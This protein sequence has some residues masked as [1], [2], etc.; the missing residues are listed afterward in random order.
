MNRSKTGFLGTAAI[1]VFALS[2]AAC[3]VQAAGS[4]GT[5]PPPPP[6]AT[7]AAPPPA[8]TTAAPA[9]TPAPAA[10]KPPAT[11]SVSGDKVAIPGNIVYETGKATL[12][13]E[14]EPVLT[15]LKTFLDDNPQVTLLRIEGHTDSDGDDAMNLKLSGERA[16]ACVN[17]LVGKGIARDRLIAVGFGESRP[18]KDNLTKENKEQNR[19]TEFRLAAIAG[20]PFLGRAADGGG[21][22]MK[23]SSGLFARSR[24]PARAD[25]QRRTR[26][27]R[28]N[29]TSG[30]N[31][32]SI[33]FCWVGCWTRESRFGGSFSVCTA[34]RA[35]NGGPC[36]ARRSA[37][38]QPGGCGRS[39]PERLPQGACG[40]DAGCSGHGWSGRWPPQAICSM[41]GA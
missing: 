13:P 7:T 40:S 3:S 9:A 36:F 2:A 8:T 6:P 24:A 38:G 35:W 17:W 10:I 33:C 32:R 22:V 30:K 16:L 37:W 12:K 14:S 21:T 19:R 23:L 41:V 39:A 1:A 15:Q 31:P 4:A 25:V 27:A 34:R 11:G 26:R 29:P 18:L 28:R 5:T 20:K